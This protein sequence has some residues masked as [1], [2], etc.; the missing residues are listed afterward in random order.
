MYVLKR[1]NTCP[2]ES[3]ISEYLCEKGKAICERI[4]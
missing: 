3:L 2:H 1:G 4:R